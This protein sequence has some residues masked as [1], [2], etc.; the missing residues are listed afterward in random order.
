MRDVLERPTLSI[1]VNYVQSINSICEEDRPLLSCW[2]V[3]KYL[4]AFQCEENCLKLR[5]R[6]S[7]QRLPNKGGVVETRVA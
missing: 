2:Q 4:I 7:S 3:E 1:D 5:D 6:F